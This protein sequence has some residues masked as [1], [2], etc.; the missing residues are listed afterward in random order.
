MPYLLSFSTCITWLNLTVKWIRDYYQ[1]LSICLFDLFVMLVLLRIV[2]VVNYCWHCL[3]QIEIIGAALLG[4]TASSLLGIYCA[5]GEDVATI[6]SRISL[7]TVFGGA[8]PPLLVVP[9]PGIFNIFRFLEHPSHLLWEPLLVVLTAF[10]NLLGI[11]LF[12]GK[13]GLGTFHA[14]LQIIHLLL[15]S[16]NIFLAIRWRIIPVSQPQQF[17]LLHG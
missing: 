13:I 14:L 5:L 15:E 1:P 17:V 4:T 7:V 11:Y 10:I 3:L 8:T 2:I 9:H 6:L 16:D 12:L